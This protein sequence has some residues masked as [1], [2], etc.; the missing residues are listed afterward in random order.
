MQGWDSLKASSI[1]F[2]CREASILSS[3]FTFLVHTPDC[4]RERLSSFVEAGYALKFLSDLWLLL[5]RSQ[6]TCTHLFSKHR[7]SSRSFASTP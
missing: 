5:M 1:E 7:W 3:N 6:K 4:E 2:N